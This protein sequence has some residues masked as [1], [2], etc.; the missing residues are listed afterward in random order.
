MKSFSKIKENDKFSVV[1]YRISICA[2][3]LELM[4]TKRNSDL[5]L[6]NMY[7]LSK[8]MKEYY[9]KYF[10]SEV[11]ENGFD[12]IPAYDYFK[13]N[14]EKIQIELVNRGKIFDFY[15]PIN[16]GF[17]G[18]WLFVN[19]KQYDE[20]LEFNRK[21]NETRDET[22]NQKLIM[23]NKVFQIEYKNNKKDKMKLLK[24]M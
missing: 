1:E 20:I 6:P 17:K 15:R 10:Y 16:G 8:V 22:Y 4:N 5:P 12:W 2:D 24:A 9:R 3:I 11:K 13:R 23:G 21:G 18:F 7:R 14:M 19:K